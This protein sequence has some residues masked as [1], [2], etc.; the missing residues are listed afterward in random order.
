MPAMNDAGR[1][2]MLETSRLVLRPHERSDFEELATIWADPEVV[3]HISGKPSSRTESWMRLVT[4]SGLWPLL[5]YGYWAIQEKQT[6]RFIGD[7]GFA[8]FHRPIEPSINGIPEAGWALASW[9]HGQGFASEALGVALAW[10][11][12]ETPYRRTVCL[13]DPNHRA[14]IRVAEK[15][16]FVAG[17]ITS[18][19]GEDTLILVRDITG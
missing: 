13:T 17:P 5:G 15:A 7:I 16:G 9:A 6:G 4:Y 14:S 1:P 19:R 2:V 11:D 10:L 12:H 8:D 3:K 18:F